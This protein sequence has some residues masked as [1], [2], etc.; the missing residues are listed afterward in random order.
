MHKRLLILCLLCLPCFIAQAQTTAFTYQ[1]HLMD[2]GA[3]ANGNYDIQFTL[4]TALTAGSTVG[5]PQIVSP[6]N[7]VN[8]IFA[9]SLDFGSAPFDGS[10]R[11]VEMAVRPFGSAAA[12]TVLAPRQ[13][14][15]STPHAVRALN[16]GAAVTAVTATNATNATNLTGTITAGNISAGTI[17][18]SM[19]AS[20][21]VQS[22]NIAAG[23]IG[24]TQLAAGSVGTSQLASGA[25]GTT[26]LAK[27]PQSGTVLGTSLPFGPP[28]AFS[29]TFPL[30]YGSAPIVTT[31]LLTTSTA[32]QAAVSVST[33]NSSATGFA[34]TVL[35]ANGART[36]IPLTGNLDVGQEVSMAIV[37][38][39]PAISYYDASRGELK[40]VRA[41][42][43]TG[44]S[45]GTP[46]TLDEMGPVANGTSLVVINGVPAVSYAA[47]NETTSSRN[48]RF[49]FATDATGSKWNS[50]VAVDAGSGTGD[51]SSLTVV[52]SNPA[53]SYYDSTTGNLKYVRATDVAGNSWGTPVT[54]D[55]TNIVGQYTSLKVI[56]GNPAI[57]YYDSTSTSLKYVRAS[58]T[59]GS[60]WNTPITVENSASVG[61]HTSMAVVSSN[62]A[63][64]Y[65]DQ[66]NGN[67]KYVRATDASGTAWGAPITVDNS[68]SNVGEY[69]SLAVVNGAPAIGYDGLTFA[70][71]T[72][73]TGSAW[74]AP[75]TIA[76][77]TN[78]FYTSLVVVGGNPALC[79]YNGGD[80]SLQYVRATNAGGTAWAAAVTADASS[81]EL[82]SGEY[83]SCAVVDGNPAVCYL[84]PANDELKFVR[85]SDTIG[86]A[87]GSPVRIN[88]NVNG[89]G[90]IN[91]HCSLAVVNGRPVVCFDEFGGL[92]FSRALDSAGTSWS[93][94]AVEVD[95]VGGEFTSLGVISGN[96]AI[97]YYTPPNVAD[98]KFVRATDANGTAWG[99]PVTIDSTGDVGQYTSLASVNGNPAI[100][101]FDATNGNLKFVRATSSTGAAWNAPLVLDSTGVVGAYTSLAVVNGNPA[102]SYYDET[103]SALKYVRATDTSG[104]AWGTPIT[105]DNAGVVGEHT[106]LAVIG[107]K[108]AITY[109]DRSNGDL[110]YVL[111]TDASGT[112]WNAPVV[113]DGAGGDYTSL[114]ELNGNAAASYRDVGNHRL[115]F[116]TG[117][118]NY[119]VNWIAL[120]P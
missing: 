120:P 31:S 113:I 115:K 102:I 4:K 76:G 103:N 8:G 33:N 81:G 37:S 48:L 116:V 62:P 50:P 90:L 58:T 69:T 41:N 104:T 119:Q 84:D 94:L 108:P 22:T 1:G 74:G 39:N 53:I 89:F 27:P 109:Y 68:A 42:D 75:T 56:N 59:T 57:S 65:Y 77:P 13:Q 30:A 15:T 51:Y 114:V 12:Y 100:S 86:S 98:L 6:V 70:R 9:V 43:T 14:L 35:D 106:S 80:G 26:Q 54:I 34:G 2:N 67:L 112:A 78:T 85:A 25:V 17:T 88:G 82:H 79:C 21:A 28:A 49:V 23:A 11:W 110:K 63:I 18:G 97:S 55:S 118:Q 20:G 3:S 117:A 111:A 32:T 99:T 45:W 87:W 10:N 95:S 47:Y 92:S 40:Y 71:A 91:G 72:D 101:Y 16:A 46:V 19:I 61:Q 105:I 73:A 44:T 7:A 36:G 29:V 38:G 96:P 5:T 60:T 83:S 107:G 64:S 24:S 66:T 93:V 52:S